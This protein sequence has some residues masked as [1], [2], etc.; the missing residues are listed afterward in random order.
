MSISD[1][2]RE[3]IRKSGQSVYAVS[4][5]SGVSQS[6]LSRFLTEDESQRQ[7]LSL[8]SIEQLAAYFGL[9]LCDEKPGGKK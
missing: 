3:A 2:L 8:N 9:R 7:N 6:S 5:G 1:Q 4:K